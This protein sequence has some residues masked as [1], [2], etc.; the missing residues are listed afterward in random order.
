M[1]ILAVGSIAYDDIITPHATRNRC[2]GGSA[3]YFALAAARYA[4]VNLVAVVGR[5]FDAEHMALLKRHGIDTSGIISKPGL[6]FYY[7]C[8]YPPDWND[9]ITH[10]TQLNVFE[11]FDP[12]IP[13]NYRDSEIV[14]LGNIAPS[15][16]RRV[17][18][19]V[20][21]PKLV[22]MDTMNLWIR[23]HR[24]DLV[25]TLG[26]VDHLLIND[27]EAEMLTGENHLIQAGRAIME[28]GPRTVCIKRGANGLLLLQGQR[29]FMLPGYPLCR[30]VDPTGAGDAFAGGLLGYLAKHG[31]DRFETLKQA[32]VVGSVMGSY[33]VESFSVD[34]LVSLDTNLVQGRYS[35]FTDL[36][37]FN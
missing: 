17:L 27:S 23:H 6:T 15:L 9:R 35:E 36:T 29:I 16:Q 33:T 20:T 26:M 19:Q 3:V 30:V 12:V 14:F 28:M 21:S 10:D 5:D 32:S 8:E 25:A 7:K 24:D 37:Q 11:Y 4:E 31:M 1:K 34:Q 22:A 13:E 18:E 2:L